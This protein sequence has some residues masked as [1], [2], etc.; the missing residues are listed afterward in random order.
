MAADDVFAVSLDTQYNGQNCVN[1]LHFI[2]IGADG[3]GTWQAALLSVWEDNFKV[4]W[5]ALMVGGVNI[6]QVRMR[7]LIP[8]QTQQTITNI[9]TVGAHTGAGMPTHAAALLRQ[10][11]LTT[12]EKG[13]GGQKIVGV[14][15]TEVANGRISKAYSDLMVA[16]GQEGE[17]DITDG[18]SQFK[19]RQVIYNVPLKSSRKVIHSDGTPRIVTVHSRQLGVGQ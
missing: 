14:P 1:V 18:T 4:P 7:R 6:V 15:V 3:T 10:R 19:F 13:T 5:I 12:D 17:V 9:G 16:Y 11:G 2:Q 8:T